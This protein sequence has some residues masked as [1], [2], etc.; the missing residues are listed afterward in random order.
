MK[1]VGEEIPPRIAVKTGMELERAKEDEGEQVYHDVMG[2]C[3]ELE[4]EHDLE[5]E[6]SDV[7]EM[8]LDWEEAGV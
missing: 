8:F 3:W 5:G 6:D 1:E 2:H 4:E 7:M